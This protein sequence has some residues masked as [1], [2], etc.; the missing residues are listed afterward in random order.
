M[1]INI[2]QIKYKKNPQVKNE[3]QPLLNLH[4]TV[5]SKYINLKTT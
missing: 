4:L 2:H 3:P 1:Y 5:P